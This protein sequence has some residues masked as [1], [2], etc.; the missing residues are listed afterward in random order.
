VVKN[1][2]PARE[3]VSRR[4][5]I[6]AHRGA[7]FHAPENTL[8]AFQMAVKTGADGVELDVRLARDGIPVVI[9]DATLERTALSNGKVS[10]FTSSELSKIGVGEWF[11]VKYPQRAR[12]EF[13]TE[14][15]PTLTDVYRLL[16]DFDGLIYVEL[17]CDEKDRIQLASAVCDVIRDS[18]LLTR[19]IVKSFDLPVIREFGAKLPAVQ[20]AA[21]FEPTL[22]GVLRRRSRLITD[23]CE[24]GASQLSV[25]YSLVTKG[26]ALLARRSNI[27]ITVW[28]VDDHKW[29]VRARRLG[30]R[31]VITNDPQKLL[32]AR[33]A[34]IP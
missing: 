8:A 12:R 13:D 28:T 25:H 16:A 24:A 27:A 5:L 23:T 6:I 2:I 9:H 32:A 31:A 1:D 10:E 14:K 20:T 30:V 21:L 34:N 3:E 17:K 29:L 19:T 11:S 26:L 15:L 22:R 18:P 4:P 7:S 33:D